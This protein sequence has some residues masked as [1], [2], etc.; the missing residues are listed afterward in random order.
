MKTWYTNI[1]HFI[2]RGKQNKKY[3][4][5]REKIIL[6]LREYFTNTD[7]LTNTIPIPIYKI[8]NLQIIPICKN[9]GSANIFLVLFEG[10]YLYLYL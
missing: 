5:E 2:G 1:C 8:Q 6:S 9:V 10:K 4:E 7:C 3:G